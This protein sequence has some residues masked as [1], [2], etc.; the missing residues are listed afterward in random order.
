MAP[1]LLA[2]INK[3][4]KLPDGLVAA[5]IRLADSAQAR[6]LKVGD[7]VDVLAARATAHEG[8]EANTVA[9]D[10]QV[11]SVP[12]TATEG[13]GGLLGSSSTVG[14]S[15]SDSVIVIAVDKATAI[16]LAAASTR[17]QLSVVVKPRT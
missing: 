12:A 6:L 10:V 17:S 13:N 15:R 14:S 1:G 16:D 11:L 3:T 9:I 2:D 5:P 8:Q 7:F 4:R